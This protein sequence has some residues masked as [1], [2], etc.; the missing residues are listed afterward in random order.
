MEEN[1]VPFLQL[2]AFN[3]AI[4][5]INGQTKVMTL[6]ELTSAM[7]FIKEHLKNCSQILPA[8]RYYD[9]F[10]DNIEKILNDSFIDGDPDDDTDIGSY[11]IGDEYATYMK[12]SDNHEAA[13]VLKYSYK[14]MYGENTLDFDPERS[15]CYVYTYDR[16]EAKQFLLFVYNKY[17]KSELVGWYDGYEKFCGELS[18]SEHK[19]RFL[20]DMI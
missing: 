14:E 4:F 9:N 16:N 7:D 1:K 18:T 6:I 19:N 15:N 20:Y 12:L 11:S 3:D 8:L 2:N 17:I 5:T 10:E 13:D